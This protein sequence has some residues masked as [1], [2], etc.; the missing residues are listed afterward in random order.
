MMS[1]CVFVTFPCGI[2]GQVWY[3]RYL[4]SILLFL[5]DHPFYMVCSFY[6][7]SL[8]CTTTF[9]FSAYVSSEDNHDIVNIKT[10][11]CN[12]IVVANLRKTAIL[13]FLGKIEGILSSSTNVFTHNFSKKMP[14]FCYF[15]SDFDEIFI[16]R[17][18][19]H[20]LFRYSRYK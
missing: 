12:C 6:R 13:T 4:P 1:N 20:S 17:L 15:S 11:T 14:Q 2:L 5:V 16:E 18:V 8:P 9:V 7:L 19:I 3:L 10:T